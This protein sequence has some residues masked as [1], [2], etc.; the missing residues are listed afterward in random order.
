[1]NAW[2]DTNSLR[3][4]PIEDFLARLGYH[5]VQR[6]ANAIWYRA[7][8]REER[9]PSLKVNP[10]KNLWFDF[11]ANKGGN[12]FALAGEFI[13]SNDF[14]LQA[15]HVAEVVDMPVKGCV[16][17][18]AAETFHSAGQ[19]FGNV[20]LRPLRNGALLG[21]LQERGILFDI[22]IANCKE[23]H[24]CIRGKRY[25]AVAFANSGGGYEIRNRF[26]KACIPP[27]DVTLVGNASNGCNIYEGFM[28]YLSACSSGIGEGEDHIVLNSVSNVAK[29]YKHLDGYGRICCYL[30]NDDAGRRALDVLRV[31]YG[32]RITDC[33][34]LYS[35]C[36]DLNEYR[37]KILAT[38]EKNEKNKSI[39]F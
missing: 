33:S 28:D 24:Y 1:M 5:P 7:P 30:D 16:P 25:F 8:Y 13:R 29:A 14:F 26:F 17:H 32:N 27:K 21:Y 15:K 22:A 20:V 3:W 34:S 2:P 36:K 4:I 23:V 31:R 11:G 6:R 18:I 9:T 10:E 35:E 39:K 38:K 12:I 19:G 37:Q